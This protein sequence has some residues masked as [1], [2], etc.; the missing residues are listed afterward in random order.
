MKTTISGYPRVGALRELKFATE[1]YFAGVLSKGELQNAAARLRETH[2]QTQIINSIDIIP[3][4]DFSLYDNIL[5]TAVLLNVVP[6]SNRALQLDP[7]DEYLYMARGYQG[8]NGDV[9][10]LAME[11]WFN[12]N[13]HYIVPEIDD[14]T[15]IALV[16]RKPF[17]EFSEARNMR[18]TTKPVV[19]G[20]FTFLKLTRFYIETGFESDMF[21]QLHKT[22]FYAR[23]LIVQVL[24]VGVLSIISNMITHPCRI[25]IGELLLVFVWFFGLVT[26]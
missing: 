21:L 10:S 11:K 20:A 5:D 12:T 4:N 22:S 2:W 14:D 24:P 3:S 15:A 17:D 8:V 16:G 1:K 9:K 19:I 6:Q 7:L 23:S 25:F 13:Y 26:L 18:I